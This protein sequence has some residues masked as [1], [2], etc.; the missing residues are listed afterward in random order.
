MKVVRQVEWSHDI[1]ED[2]CWNRDLNQVFLI[3]ERSV[4]KFDPETLTYEK[5]LARVPYKGCTCSPTILYLTIYTVREVFSHPLVDLH[6]RKY[7]FKC[8]GDAIAYFLL[9]LQTLPDIIHVIYH[10]LV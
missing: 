3:S 4:L 2:S 10:H 7:V 9:L 1:V 6:L 5:I 8:F